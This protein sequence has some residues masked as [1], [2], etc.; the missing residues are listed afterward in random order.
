MKLSA[1]ES[2]NPRGEGGGGCSPQ[3]TIR[4]C[5]ALKP[6]CGFWA[7]LVWKRVNILFEKSGKDMVFTKYLRTKKTIFFICSETS[8]MYCHFPKFQNKS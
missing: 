5:A 7:N 6:G 3:M 1:K 4:V 2:C 8:T